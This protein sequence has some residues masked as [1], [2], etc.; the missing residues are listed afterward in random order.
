MR[1]AAVWILTSAG[2]AHAPGTGLA[3]RNPCTIEVATT[4]TKR[5]NSGSRTT[6]CDFSGMAS[7][8]STRGSPSFVSA[9]VARLPDDA[10][11]HR[12]RAF[13]SLDV[14]QIGGRASRNGRS[15]GERDCAQEDG[16]DGKGA[17]E[18]FHPNMP[19]AGE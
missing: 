15:G 8:S 7:Y 12:R 4:L 5:A 10:H 1:S 17:V 2:C 18:N 19:I 16:E 9:G 13:A 14:H 3:V 11:R 6:N